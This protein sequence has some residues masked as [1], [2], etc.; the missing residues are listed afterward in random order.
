MCNASEVSWE[1][2]SSS[3]ATDVIQTK[4]EELTSTTESAA[5]A[6][7]DGNDEKSSNPKVIFVLMSVVIHSFRIFI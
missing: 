6:V 2:P 4:E 1:L 3:E 7:A 5:A